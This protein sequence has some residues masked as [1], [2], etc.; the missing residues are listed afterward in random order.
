M[1]TVFIAIEE[2]SRVLQTSGSTY[3]LIGIYETWDKA[4]KVAEAWATNNRKYSYFATEEANINQ[5]KQ[6][7]LNRVYYIPFGGDLDSKYWLEL[8]IKSV[9][10]Q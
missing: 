4:L 8:R 6:Q 5:E 3:N 7:Y 1:K 10:V 9:E 2:Y